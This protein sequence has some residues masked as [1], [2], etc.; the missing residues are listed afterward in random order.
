MVTVK[1]DD[2]PQE[3]KALEKANK[4]LGNSTNKLLYIVVTED[5][6]IEAK[7][8]Y[9]ATTKVD[10]NAYTVDLVGL[11]VTNAQNN[12]LETW[13]DAIELAKEGKLEMQSIAFPWHRIISI[14]NVSYKKAS[15]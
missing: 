14:K 4:L 9:F 5:P 3:A 11:E 2:G 1:W 10:K 6:S 8:R 13:D 15:A 12:K 7:I